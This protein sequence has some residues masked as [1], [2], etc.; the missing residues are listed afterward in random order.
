[1]NK[2]YFKIAVKIITMKNITKVIF[3]LAVAIF[4]SSHAALA[5]YIPP[6]ANPSANGVYAP[7]G[8]IVTAQ[9]VFDDS[10]GMIVSF[11]QE[12]NW[13]THVPC[14]P[15]NRDGV[16]IRAD[17]YSLK[18]W[19]VGEL[20]YWQNPTKDYGKAVMTVTPILRDYGRLMKYEKELKDGNVACVLEN[21]KASFP[22]Q[23]KPK[24]YE[25][26]FSGGPDGTFKGVSDVETGFTG[27]IQ[28]KDTVI[29]VWDSTK[30]EMPVRF[31]LNEKAFAAWKEDIQ[32]KAG[33]KIEYESSGGGFSD[34]FGQVE[35]NIPNAD[36]TYDE[37]AWDTA[38]LDKKTLPVGTRIKTGEKSG[39]LFT[40]FDN[41]SQ[42]QMGPN[43]ELIIVSPPGEPG[44]FEMLHGKLK[45]E[46]KKMM[47]DGSMEIEMSQAVAGIKGTT[48]VLEETKDK[49]TIKVIEGSVAYKSKTSGQTEMVN[50]GETLIADRN[51]LGQKTTFDVA[52]ENAVWNDLA[53]NSGKTSNSSK[54]LYYV[55][56]IAVLAAVAVSLW[57]I[58]RKKKLIK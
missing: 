50:T 23:I 10:L 19:D 39:A 24:I 26:T 15:G 38:Q 49:S 6:N 5:N 35:V 7:Q 3:V 18:F 57:M 48:F 27:H 9:Q 33:Q 32:G 8:I 58:K 2:K 41:Q 40:S 17:E 4:V 12:G 11:D 36:G 55:G 52:A 47:K 1:M 30:N 44:Q 14:I 54:T 21:E 53:D 37:E 51:G 42:F 16:G 46:V 31:K 22:P 34:L 20:T 28:D 43:S 25:I 29:F 45:A 56:V 13:K